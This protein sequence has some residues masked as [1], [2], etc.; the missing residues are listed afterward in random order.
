MNIYKLEKKATPGP[1]SVTENDVYFKVFHQE[2]AYCR[3]ANADA[4]LLAH[5]RNHFMEALEA[6]KEQHE[7]YTDLLY[8]S[9]SGNHSTHL[10]GVCDLIKKL[11]TI[12]CV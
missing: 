1:V 2:P 8:S 6:L 3:C 4:K 11:E 9:G 5:C 10:C 12:E 7:Y